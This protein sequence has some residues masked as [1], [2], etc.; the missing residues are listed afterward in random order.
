M[1]VRQPV[2]L[3]VVITS[4]NGYR[5]VARC[6]ASLEEQP[7]RAGTELIVVE[8]SGD[9]TAARISA[10]FPAVTVIRC[11]AMRPLPELRSRGIREAKAPIVA[12]TKDG[13]VLDAHWSRRVLAAHARYPDAAIGG[14][15][16]HD[17]GA[18]LV[19]RAAHIC[20]YGPFMRPFRPAPAPSVAAPNVS[21]KRALLEAACGDLLERGAW[22]HVLHAR[23]RARGMTLRLEPSIVVYHTR[24]FGL[25][26]FLL[27]RYWFGRSFAAARVA[28]A[29]TATRAFWTVV[30]PFLAPLFLWRYARS[31]VRRRRL[32]EL[33][34][35]LPLLAGFA[36]AWSAGEL[37]GYALGDGGASRR[38]T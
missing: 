12:T 8:A 9:E 20:E 31:A 4:V 37:L 30:C 10:E 36:L 34:A 2:A 24:R 32:G 22:E 11:D 16:E 26:E 28:T 25:V 13:C 15:V 14:A 3:S 6:L 19:D 33:V 29:T 38:V 7:D 5:S 17:G 23:L 1:P 35:A 18:R 27:Q 21:Y